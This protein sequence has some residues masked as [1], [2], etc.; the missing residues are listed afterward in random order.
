MFLDSD[1]NEIRQLLLRACD[2]CLLTRKH[3]GSCNVERL[4]GSMEGIELSSHKPGYLV[5]AEELDI[6]T[7]PGSPAYKE[8]A[9]KWRNM[10]KK[11]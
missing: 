9:G 2:Q 1:F 6:L 5:S 7:D 4:L 11:N 10:V 8:V 3:C